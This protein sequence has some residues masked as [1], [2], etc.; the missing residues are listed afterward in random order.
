MCFSKQCDKHFLSDDASKN[1]VKGQRHYDS[2]HKHW[3][4]QKLELWAR[5]SSL[6][7]LNLQFGGTSVTIET[8][9][10]EKLYIFS[11]IFGVSS[12][13]LNGQLLPFCVL[14]ITSKCMFRLKFA[15]D[16]IRTRDLSWW[17][18]PLGQLSHNRCLTNFSWK[19]FI[20]GIQ[21]ILH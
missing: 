14:T 1:S 12:I 17:K 9:I 10:L 19:Q 6:R 13:V 20:M 11:E 4:N 8:C 15:N 7:I 2:E 16:C 21:K 3:T 18:Q 5:Y